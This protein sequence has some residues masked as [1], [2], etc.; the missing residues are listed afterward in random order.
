MIKIA[1]DFVLEET[2]AG[3]TMV[4]IN[5][6]HEMVKIHYEITEE[7]LYQTLIGISGQQFFNLTIR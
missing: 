5:K 2:R 7:L 4:S 6:I 1:F 3:N